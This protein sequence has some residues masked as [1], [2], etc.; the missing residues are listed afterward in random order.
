MRKVGPSLY[1]IAEK[2]NGSWA[3]K[4]VHSPRGF[5]PDTKMPHF[6]G[7]STNNPDYLAKEDREIGREKHPQADLPDAEMY[8]IA[9]YLFRESR[10]YLGGE[11]SYFKQNLDRRLLLLARQRAEADLRKKLAGAEGD[12]KKTLETQA[13]RAALTD[14]DVKELN[15]VGNRLETA[16][17]YNQLAAVEDR[18]LT[19][20]QALDR[21]K[22]GLA[23]LD[24]LPPEPA[25]LKKL[26]QWVETG[27][28]GVELLPPEPGKLQEAYARLR[29]LGLLPVPFAQRLTDEQGKVVPLP[30]PPAAGKERDTHLALGNRLFREKGCLACHTHEA[31]AKAG[32][33][34]TGKHPLP[35]V[36]SE[37]DFGPN[38]SRLAAKLKDGKGEATRPWLVQWIMNPKVYHPRTRMPVTHLSAADAAAVA[39]WLLAQPTDWKG[40]DVAKPSA[41][42]LKELVRL[43]LEKMLTRQDVDDGFLKSS[44]DEHFKHLKWD[45]DE[46]ALLGGLTEDK[47]LWY[48][49]KRAINRL[50]CF[51]CHSIPGFESAKPIG[52]PLNDWGK[53]D[54]ERLAFESVVGYVKEKAEEKQLLLVDQLSEKDAK[55]KE[56]RP[57]QEAYE[58]YFFNALEH[59]TRDGFL[60][61]K[62]AEPRS[63]DYHRQVGWEDRLRMPQF[64]F[65]H[66]PAVKPA[67]GEDEQ[68]ARVRAEA[69][70]R[71]AVMTF[72]L[73]LVA[74]PIPLKYVHQPSGDRLAE[75]KGRQVLDKFNCAGCHQVR[76]GVYEFRRDKVF[77]TLKGVIDDPAYKSDMAKD[78]F[79]PDHNAW[80][81]RPQ[82]VADRILVHANLTT[83]FKNPETDENML[84]LRL[85][86]ALRFL[87]DPRPFE[88]IPAGRTVNL[89]QSALLPGAAEPYGGTFASL[90]RGYVGQRG[91]GIWDDATGNRQ[92]AALPPPLLREGERTQPGWLYQFLKDPGEVR[93]QFRSLDNGQRSEGILL[94]RMPRFNLSDDDV[95]A[96]VGYFAAADRLDNPAFGLEYPYLTIREKENSYLAARS[97]EYA[98]RL[99]KDDLNRKA[100]PLYPIWTAEKVSAAEAAVKA[101]KE[102]AARAPKDK[103]GEARKALQKAEKELSA[104]KEKAATGSLPHDQLTAYFEAWK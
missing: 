36:T 57:G 18:H 77:D 34:E 81:G 96:L 94:L 102:E 64:R 25:A 54:P 72:V 49:G 47:M 58:K 39:D 84:A 10:G 78:H 43:P 46:R 29:G 26:N 21:A 61:Q 93:P 55:F 37:A 95:H 7:L 98:R 40:D 35:A 53:K 99:G 27:K 73:G 50:G 71:D 66:G 11:D 15:E 38:L 28:D 5:R 63:F 56:L 4:W 12:E 41:D 59:H 16:M 76:S 90:M 89:P 101:A 31:T 83:T 103:Q 23:M 2:T 91:Y 97:A 17:R 9:Y 20:E 87:P 45:A 32:T 75:V 104:L 70:A 52:T 85:N 24:A 22:E 68:Q 65:A 48:A 69:E 1:R 30:K 79:F 86:Q 44:F 42:T 13:A 88:D 92:R 74:E 14:R 62:L 60:H 51:G 67:E 8:A 3:R 80:V 19:P 82:P 33:D 100:E 6:Y